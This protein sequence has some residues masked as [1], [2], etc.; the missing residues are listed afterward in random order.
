MQ[1]QITNKK[2]LL[3]SVLNAL[4][5]TS[6]NEMQQSKP[7][8]QSAT[9]YTATSVLLTGKV[10]GKTGNVEALDDKNVVASA[11]VENGR[12][13]LEIPAQTKLPLELHYDKFLTVVVDAD[14][15]SYDINS[16]T[17]NIA[18]KAK[19]LG[20]YTRQNM[21]VAASNS[22]HTPDANKTSTGFRGD[23]TS[24]YGGWH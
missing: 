8:M 11:S 12:Y 2:L 16:L 6:C 1:M 13:Q 7:A 19:T 23:P 9:K 14:L 3:I 15:T 4:L 5:L 22:V 21:I 24:Q 20:G 18:A 10:E 17:T